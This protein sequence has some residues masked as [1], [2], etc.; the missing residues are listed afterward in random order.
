MKKTIL[1]LSVLSAMLFAES[2]V[3][4]SPE[5][6]TP[7]PCE[8]IA[9]AECHIGEG[10][11]VIIEPYDICDTHGICDMPIVNDNVFMRKQ[12]KM[13]N[14]I[15]AKQAKLEGYKECVANSLDTK[16]LKACKKSFKSKSRK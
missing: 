5:M 15:A 4:I 2:P 6:P 16:D 13:E 8:L 3:V 14:M 9:D 11:E 12:A 7:N 1:T 10:G